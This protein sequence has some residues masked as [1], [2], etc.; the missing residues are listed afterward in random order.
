MEITRRCR[1]LLPGSSACVGAG[2]VKQRRRKW[3]RLSVAG[4]R[5]CGAVEWGI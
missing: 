4:A 3:N 1:T 2:D 5:Q